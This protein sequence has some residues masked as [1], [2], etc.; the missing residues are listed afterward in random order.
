MGLGKSKIKTESMS[1]PRNFGL[2]AGQ[3]NN[4]EQLTPSLFMRVGTR[5]GTITAYYQHVNPVNVPSSTP[6]LPVLQ[7]TSQVAPIVTTRTVH[8]ASPPT[9]TVSLPDQPTYDVPKAPK[10]S[11]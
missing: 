3:V 5:V 1:E 11:Q 4:R 7:G 6:N 9:G 2:P 10:K 8:F